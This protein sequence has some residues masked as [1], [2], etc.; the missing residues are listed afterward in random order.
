M[1]VIGLMSGTSADAI[2]AAVVAFGREGDALALRL[3]GYVERPYPPALRARLL[4][5]LPPAAGATQEVCELGALVGEA[6]AEAAHDAAAAA[7]LPVER[8]DLV[9]SH[10][11]TVYHQVAPGHPR[12]TLQIG[13]PAVIAERT[14]CTVAADFRPRDVAAG[15]QGAPLLPLLDT[16]LLAHPERSRALQNIGGIANVTWLPATGHGRQTADHSTPELPSSVAGGRWSARAFDT[17]PGNCLIDELAHALSGGRLRLDEGGAWALQGTPDER[18]LAAWLEDPYFALPPPKSTGREYF[19]RA[20]AARLLAEC[21]ARSLADADAL[22]TVTALTARAIALAYRRWLP[23]VPDEVLLSGGGAHNRALVSMLAAAL[24]E[25]QVRPLGAVGLPGDAKEAVGFALLGYYA[26]HGWPG[27]IPA[28]TGAAHPAVLGSLTPGH[29][30]RDLVRRALAEER[31]PPA[32]ALWGGLEGHSP[33][34][35]ENHQ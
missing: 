19:S 15:G 25:S 5:L 6:F 20:Y 24:P 21:H 28:C 11:Q 29:N 33:S 7:R 1:I 8:V 22:A 27:N 16:L 31:G 13:A 4:A 23:H 17:G 18:L 26:L 34:K 10:G 2:D 12:A 14:G 30:Y 9:A 3:L 35:K 32:R